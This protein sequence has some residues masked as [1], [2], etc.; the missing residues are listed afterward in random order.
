[1]TIDLWHA[2]VVTLLRWVAS[3][4]VI[5]LSLAERAGYKISFM[6]FLKYGLVVTVMSLLIS[7]V[8]VWLRYLN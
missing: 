7:T 2:L 1:M 8:Y 3:A 5:V 6:Q 4:N